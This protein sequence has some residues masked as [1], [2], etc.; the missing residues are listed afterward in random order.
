MLPDEGAW[1]QWSSAGIL[2][3]EQFIAEF[4]ARSY[5]DKNDPTATSKSS[6][7]TWFDDT[8]SLYNQQLGWG[9]MKSVEFTK[10]PQEDIDGQLK[11]NFPFFLL[12]IFLFPFKYITAQISSEK[13]SKAREGMKMMGLTDEVYYLSWFIC[14]SCILFTCT[15]ICTIFAMQGIFKQING[16]L[17][18]LFIFLFGLTLYG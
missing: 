7:I 8:S 4:I 2:M 14:Y 5:H 1:N 6:N 16:V 17:F 18:F 11:G 13:E 12:I 15:I 9:A 3:F 10:V